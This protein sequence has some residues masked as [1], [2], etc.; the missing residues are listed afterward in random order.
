MTAQIRYLESIGVRFVGHGLRKDFRV[1]NCTLPEQ[2]VIDTVEL[3]SLP[4]VAPVR[5]P[6]HRSFQYLPS[7]RGQRKLSLRFLAWLLLKVDM[8][9]SDFCHDSVEDA[10]A[11]LK[12]CEDPRAAVACG[13]LHSSQSDASHLPSH[14][15]CTICTA[16]CRRSPASSS[17]PL[18]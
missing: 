7:S 9:T 1:I 13:L 12:V 14:F 18:T 10:I 11:A 3:F 17:P 2:Q 4:Y 16:S 8:Q 5:M 6:S 15:S